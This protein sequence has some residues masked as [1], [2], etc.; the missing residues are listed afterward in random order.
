MTNKVTAMSVMI[1][2]MALRISGTRGVA[3]AD[4]T[5]RGYLTTTNVAMTYPDWNCPSAPESA[6]IFSVLTDCLLPDSISLT[7]P[8]TLLGRE[9]LTTVMAAP[10]KRHFVVST[11]MLNLTMIKLTAGDISGAGNSMYNGY[12]GAINI[13]GA[14]SL[15]VTRCSFWNNTAHGGGAIFA[16]FGATVSVRES[17]LYKNSAAG[18]MGHQIMTKS[19]AN[20]VVVNSNFTNLFLENNFW[21]DSNGQSSEANYGVESP[22]ATCSGSPCT[23][24]P[25]TGRCT[26]HSIPNF[27]VMCSIICPGQGF[28]GGFV[29]EKI[30][31]PTTSSTACSSCSAGSFVNLAG[32]ENCTICA[33]GE[34]IELLGQAKCKLCSVGKYL[35]DRGTELLLHDAVDDCVACPAG[36]W[37][38][39]S[40]SATCTSV[41]AIIRG[42]RRQP[43]CDATSK[44][45]RP[46]LLP[47][48]CVTE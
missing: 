2:Q 43:T 40:G 28:A 29:S 34:Y 48:V 23:E 22:T 14:G 36:Q 30:L 13:V 3:A 35:S 4:V 31:P 33:A 41:E 19:E 47:R 10:G 17:L 20:I 7:G 18:G 16:G 6:L 25:Y 1:P 12:G 11:F 9:G 37:T 39:F 44:G 21:S 27:G 26:N 42:Y 15:F 32:Q 45:L 5:G 38:P 46:H 8:L 24:L